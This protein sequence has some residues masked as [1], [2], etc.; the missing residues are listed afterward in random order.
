M[1]R[2]L[3]LYN[4]LIVSIAYLIKQSRIIKL[5]DYFLWLLQ[6]WIG[7]LTINWGKSLGIWGTTDVPVAW[8]IFSTITR[9]LFRHCFKLFVLWQFRQKLWQREWV[10]TDPR[11]NI[12][13]PV[14]AFTVLGACV[15]RDNEWSCCIRTR[16][17]YVAYYGWCLPYLQQKITVSIPVWSWHEKKKRPKPGFSPG[18]QW[19]GI[20][21]SDMTVQSKC[22]TTNH[23]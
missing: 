5:L 14:D 21:W 6:S 22:W 7:A 12:R 18:T 17:E 1:L 3:I 13:L 11:V 2:H 10:W 15:K 16:I 9:P 19:V 23:C 8:H 20:S 4:L